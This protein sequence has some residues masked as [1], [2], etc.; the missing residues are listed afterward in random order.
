M[1]G[2]AWDSKD[3]PNA[4]LGDV[5]G[6]QLGS[7]IGQQTLGVTVSGGQGLW[8]TT[9]RR[10]LW[11]FY[12]YYVVRR[13][14]VFLTLFALPTNV[15]HCVH[16]RVTMDFPASTL[17]H[18]SSKT[19]STSRGMTQ[20]IHHSLRRVAAIQNACCRILGALGIASSFSRDHIDCFNDRRSMF[21]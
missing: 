15:D 18:P 7:G 1:I 11:S 6:S 2:D 16:P 20:A 5:E 3:D 13:A 12:L 8:T 19:C 10:E 9:T 17:V 4:I 21:S 14:R